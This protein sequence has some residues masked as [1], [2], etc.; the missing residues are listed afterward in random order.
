[1]SDSDLPSAS[2]EPV[3]P[4]SPQPESR[5]VDW[6]LWVV[7][8]AIAL[9]VGAVIYRSR[10]K[11]DISPGSAANEQ[12]PAGQEMTQEQ[13]LAQIRLRTEQEAMTMTVQIDDR[14][15]VVVRGGGVIPDRKDISAPPV[16]RSSTVIDI[17]KRAE[18][19]EPWMLS[20][21]Y[22]FTR[23]GEMPVFMDSLPFLPLGDTDAVQMD[24]LDPQDAADEGIDPRE[25]IIGV[26]VDGK[27]RA[28]PLFYA[29]MHDVINDTIAGRP[30]LITW[31]PLAGAPIISERMDDSGKPMVF[32]NAGLIYEWG[33]VIYDHE[34]NSLWSA[35]RREAICGPLTGKRMAP[36]SCSVVAWGAWKKAYPETT[37]LAG[38]TPR[39]PMN[40]REEL[41][42]PTPSYYFDPTLFYALY[43]FD[44]LNSTIPAKAFVFG[45]ALPNGAA[46]AYA[47]MLLMETPGEEIEDDIG[48]ARVKVKLDKDTLEFIA[49]D[50]EGKRLVADSMMYGAWAAM[51]PES[52][53]WQ[54]DKLAIPTTTVP[55]TLP[56]PPTTV[57]VAP[58]APPAPSRP[59]QPW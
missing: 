47:H 23:E 6:R 38:T 30:I 33:N 29:H 35:L 57:P 49:L 50:A 3:Q 41:A 7:I 8:G 34:T 48:G 21:R 54:E 15:Y 55:A 17:T 32:G 58:T 16:R 5:G 14:T 59:L 12:V 46:K 19:V 25:R 52:E 9:I 4:E 36:I 53:I 39:L 27:P 1:M 40:Y 2:G 56:P 43:G 10:H 20:R 37:I 18:G 44:I 28:Y 42:L 22:V 45:I 13:M 26:V 11:P 31:N 24:V 51:H